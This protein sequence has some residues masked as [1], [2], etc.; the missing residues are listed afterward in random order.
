MSRQACGLGGSLLVRGDDGEYSVVQDV[1]IQDVARC[2]GVHWAYI[3]KHPP[4]GVGVFVGCCG[5]KVMRHSRLALVYLL[6]TICC[7]DRRVVDRL[8][9]QGRVR[10][11]HIC[12]ETGEGRELPVP[13]DGRVHPQVASP[14]LAISL[15]CI[16]YSC[17]DH[18]LLLAKGKR[19]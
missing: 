15:V 12:G 1:F 4:N 6:R 5:A 13:L 3:E 10:I 14:R 17:L 11:A 2:P 16:A 19:H 18:H 9:R 8:A 7:E